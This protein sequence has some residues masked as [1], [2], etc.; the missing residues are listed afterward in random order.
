MA[1]LAPD[2]IPIIVSKPQGAARHLFLH[3]PAFGQTKEETKPVLDHLAEKG[4]AAVGMDIWQQGERGHESR[5]QLTARVFGNFQRN[6]WPILGQTTL[7]ISR[8]IDWGLTEFDLAAPAFISGLS[9]G[10]DIA[11]A[12]AGLDSRISN[13]VAVGSTPDWKRPG[14]HDVMDATKL[15]PSGE[16]DPY[17]QFF[18][19]Q[20]NPLTHLDR[21]AR[22]PWLNFI[23]CELDNHIPLDGVKRFKAALSEKNPQAGERISLT[24]LPDRRHVDLLDLDVWWPTASALI[25]RI[26]GPASSQNS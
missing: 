15:L 9:L 5:N 3:L 20:L 17:A 14:M 4:F 10:G 22:G 7:D 21:Y 8:V 24:M 26:D 6:M 2:G 12:A 25:D 18:Y 13:V 23:S 11:V 1:T 16:P 19:D